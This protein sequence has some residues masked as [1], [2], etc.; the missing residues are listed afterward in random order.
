MPFYICLNR[1]REFLGYVISKLCRFDKIYD[2][3]KF[4]LVAACNTIEIDVGFTCLLIFVQL[5][6]LSVSGKCNFCC[7][8]AI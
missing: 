4:E 7:Q 5:L 2:R 6:L 8:C 3:S 1:I